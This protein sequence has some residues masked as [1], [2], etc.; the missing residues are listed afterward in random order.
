MKNILIALCIAVI[1]FSCKTKSYHN[2]LSP[3]IL[4]NVNCDNSGFPF[5]SNAFY[6]P[7]ESYIDSIH[8][9]IQS[10]PRIVNPYPFSKEEFS[11]GYNVPIEHLKDSFLTFV[12]TS[13][14]QSF[15]NYL[16]VM[17]EPILYT[18]YLNKEIYRLTWLRSF[19]PE[20]VITLINDKD[21]IFL[22][23]KIVNDQL[24]RYFYSIGN[25]DIDTNHYDT[26][27]KFKVLDTTR[28]DYAQFK[29]FKR[30]IE[31][32]GLTCQSPLGISCPIKDGATWTFES[33]LQSG[34]HFIQ[35]NSRTNK[36]LRI[37]GDYLI[38]LGPARTEEKY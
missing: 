23:T 35:R 2:C 26:T 28:I 33:H 22:I 3:Y 20:V 19:H 21:S 34:Y 13:G 6:L 15:S 24:S 17:E 14:L 25:S 12:D 38:D 30:L 37:V 9:V 10:D 4:E 11:K 36:D 1:L 32:T 29:E 18:K 7:I 8:L 31:Q 16:F 27:N 5:D